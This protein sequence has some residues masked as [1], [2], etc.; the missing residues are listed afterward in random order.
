MEQQR[1]LS[2]S[3]VI[4]MAIDMTMAMV[5][6]AEDVGKMEEFDLAIIRMVMDWMMSAEGR[7]TG[8]KISVNIAGT[9][10]RWMP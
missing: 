3:L 7:R 5:A 1:S 4:A 8:A 10:V 9:S 2:W 6:F